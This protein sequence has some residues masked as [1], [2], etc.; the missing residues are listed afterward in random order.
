MARFSEKTI[1]VTGA[2]GGVGAAI[3]QNLGEEG[4]T[5]CLSGRN[6]ERLQEIAGQLSQ[7]GRCYPGDLTI[8]KEM[9]DVVRRMLAENP[10][11]DGVIHG[12]AI[13]ALAPVATGSTEDFENQFKTN[14]LAPYRLTQLLLPALTASRGQVIFLNSSAGLVARAEVS[15]YAATK[16]ALKAVADSLRE[17][18]NPA[19]VRVCSLFLGAIATSMQESVRAYQ[20]RDYHPESLIQPRDV[21]GM[22]SVL[23]ALPTTSEVTDVTM[24]PTARS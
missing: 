3:A 17:E 7:P 4:A 1:L 14:V 15:Q 9:D 18:C 19:G 22:V 13:I 5:V 12:A 23:L 11:L 21:A 24:R 20:K 8:D 16:H 2:S 6:S 10:R